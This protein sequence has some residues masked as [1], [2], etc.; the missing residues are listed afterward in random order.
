MGW[1]WA[2]RTLDWSHVTDH[3]SIA[4]AYLAVLDVSDCTRIWCL[5]GKRSSDIMDLDVV[6]SA[7]EK[8]IPEYK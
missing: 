5:K 2:G 6:L 8:T 3:Q 7:F 1:F 4:L